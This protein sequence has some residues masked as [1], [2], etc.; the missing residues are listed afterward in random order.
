LRNAGKRTVEIRWYTD[1]LQY[2]NLTVTDPHGRNVAAFPYGSQ[3]APSWPSPR[4]LK[5][6]PGESYSASVNLLGTVRE[7]DL[8]PGIY[9]I[10]ARYDYQGSVAVSNAVEVSLVK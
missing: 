6:A 2:L 7:E 9:H 5:L 1:P 10:Q 4:I 3:F 8:A